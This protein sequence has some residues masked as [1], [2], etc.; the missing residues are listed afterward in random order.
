MAETDQLT[1]Q[2]IRALRDAGLRL[3]RTSGRDLLAESR[4]RIERIIES[5]LTIESASEL[6]RLP[7]QDVCELVEAKKLYAIQDTGQLRLPRFQFHNELLVTCFDQIAPLIPVH[8]NPIDVENWFNLPDPDLYID[9]EQETT[10][11]PRAWLL[12]GRSPEPIIAV[13][14]LID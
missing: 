12:D 4:K 8:W 6:L 13:L 9:E 10:L 14:R 1:S 11:S 3:E 2:E 7:V 5:S